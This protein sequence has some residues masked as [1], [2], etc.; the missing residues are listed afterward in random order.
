MEKIWLRPM[1]IDDMDLIYQWANEPECR[2]N[3]FHME[4]I[5]YE[6]HKKWFQAKL[7]SKY[8]DM[9]VACREK[10]PIGQIRLEYEGDKALISYSVTK[11]ERGRGY[12][13]VLLKLAEEKVRDKKIN[14][15]VLEGLVKEHNI[16]SQ[17]KF[18]EMGYDKQ[19]KGSCFCYQKRLE[20]KNENM[21]RM[22]K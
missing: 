6:D 22:L 3:S 1:Q 13:G 11:E 14:I 18:E 7:I 8:C 20:V 9:F 2:K 12:G 17:R 21:V 5:P 19:K 16:A 4:K 15:H 10:T